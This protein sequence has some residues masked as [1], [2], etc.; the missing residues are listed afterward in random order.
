[1]KTAV[2]MAAGMGTRLEERTKDMPKGFLKIGSVPIIEESIIKL[3]NVGIE[4]IFIGTGYLSEHFDRLKDFYPVELIKSEKFETTS[5]MYTLYNMRDRIKDDFLLLESDLMYD[6]KGLNYLLE[7]KENDV[8]LSSGKTNSGDEVYI[9]T[10]SNGF[11]VNMSKKSDDLGSIN[12]ELVGITKVSYNTFKEMCVYAEKAFETNPKIDYE[13]VLVGITEEL[14]YSV[15]VVE[16]YTWCEID[17][18]SHLKRANELI[19][20]EILRK[21]ARRKSVKRNILLNPGPA[22]TTDTVK[23]AQVVPDICPREKE[24]ADLVRKVQ[25][26]MVDIV[27]GGDEYASVFFAGSGTAIMDAVIN[28]VVPGDGKLC[29]IVNGAYGSR[30]VKIAEAYS[31]DHMVIDFGFGGK[32]DLEKVESEIAKDKEIKCVAVVHHETTTG[33]LNPVDRIADLKAKYNFSFVV[34]GISTYAGLPINIKESKIDFLLST[35]NKCIQGMAGLSFAICKIDELIK[36]KDFPVRSFYLNLYNQYIHFEEKGQ[37]QF[38]PP[39]QILYA[40]D[41]AVKEY[42]AEGETARYERYDACWRKYREELPKLGFNFLHDAE[43]D[44]KVLLTIMEPD[45]PNYSFNR[46]H[47]YLYERGFT[48]YPGKVGN[49]NTF[50][51][52]NIGDVHPE[53]IENFI[54]VLKQYVDKELV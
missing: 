17:D 35:S 24:F 48:I 10:D 23:Y 9:E 14:H 52:S 41:Q 25:K 38:T 3:L 26:D 50:R 45:H 54:K 12:G 36:T 31:I 6:Q 43:E 5:S 53:D 15:K 20:P 1:M 29:I 4:K 21:E 39:V 28:S 7:A 30:M 40:L 47:D 32:I 18:E 11:L 19:Y 2:I 16:D 42:Y 22:T 37:W 44:S 51:L 27:H 13:T 8:I 34:D 46:M 49:K 33:I